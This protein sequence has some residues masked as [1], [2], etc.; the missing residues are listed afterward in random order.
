M[1][2][3]DKKTKDQI[4]DDRL[5]DHWNKIEALE[6]KVDELS[7][8]VSNPEWL[9]MLILDLINEKLKYK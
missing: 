4:Q 1:N 8:K 3:P 2:E 5:N 6:K 7:L 9:D